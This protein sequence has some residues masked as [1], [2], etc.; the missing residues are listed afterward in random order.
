M[1]QAFTST[2]FTG[3]TSIL[4][5]SLIRAGGPFGNEGALTIEPREGPL[6]AGNILV[7]DLDFE[8]SAFSGIDLRGPFAIGNVSLNNL[9]VSGAGN[10]GVQVDADANGSVMASGIVVNNPAS[11]GLN[12]AAGGAFI[13]TRGTSNVGW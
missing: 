4:R 11:G 5:T 8:S 13:I 7:Q 2:P 1:A 3:T 6:A 9:T 10:W 12:N